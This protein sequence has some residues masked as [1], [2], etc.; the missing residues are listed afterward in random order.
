MKITFWGVRGSIPTPGLDTVRYG[1][2]TSCI[3]LDGDD[4]TVLIFD[5]GT[6]IRLIGAKLAPLSPLEIHLFLTHTHWDHIHG[7][8]F[9][10]PAFIPNNVI[11]IYGPPHFDKGLKEIMSQQMVY[12]YFPVNA[13]ELQAKVRYRDLKEETLSIG[14]LS[15]TS[16]LMNHPVTCFAYR[17]VE[18][19]KS[20]VYTGDNE[21][22]YN[23]LA[24]SNGADESERTE[25]DMIVKEQNERNVSFIKDADL[26][27]A[28]SQYTDDEY[29]SKIGWGHS[30]TTQTLNLAI[31]AGVK[32]MVIFHHDPTHTDEIM[33][34]IFDDI[35][36]KYA[37][38]GHTG[39]EI[40][41]AREGMEI[42]L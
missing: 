9:F 6:G 12:S 5:S 7:F 8:P 26:L 23:F 32:R 14:D 13:D 40:S 19:G 22:Y 35:M 29:P 37:A 20:V 1:G 3:G 31:E 34:S 30:A 36:K 2:N 16:K 18:N 15:I 25:I 21:P 28:E 27:I 39:M 33:D 10:S 17:V 42:V 11:N 4:G 24:N 41:V 38:T